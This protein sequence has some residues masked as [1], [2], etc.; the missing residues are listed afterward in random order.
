MINRAC[1]Y[2]VNMTN[3]NIPDTA[4]ASP[5]EIYEA[6]DALYWIFNLG[7]GA[8]DPTYPVAKALENARAEMHRYSMQYR[9]K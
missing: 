1:W 6:I 8:N 4:K 3:I 2:N 7:R 5:K 9:T